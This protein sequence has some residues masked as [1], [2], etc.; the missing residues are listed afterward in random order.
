[1]SKIESKPPDTAPPRKSSGLVAL[2]QELALR[3]TAPGPLGSPRTLTGGTGGP[4]GSPGSP[5]GLGSTLRP[6]PQTLTGA[7]SSLGPPRNSSDGLRPGAPSPRAR[8]PQE[9]DPALRETASADSAR[10]AEF[11]AVAAG[12]LAKNRGARP[13]VFVSHQPNINQIT[14]ELIADGDLLVAKADGKGA[15]DVLG[16]LRIA[17]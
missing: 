4:G 5:G 11:D 2:E 10:A 15:L 7:A 12:L 3:E 14:M 13:V 1:M 6:K 17:P 16:K 9:E 8:P